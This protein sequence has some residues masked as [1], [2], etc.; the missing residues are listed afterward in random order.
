[1]YSAI[2]MAIYRYISVSRYTVRFRMLHIQFYIKSMKF[3]L[4]S[5]K[6][7]DPKENCMLFI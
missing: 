2:Y 1:M 4:G 3:S 6:T 7:K 5:F